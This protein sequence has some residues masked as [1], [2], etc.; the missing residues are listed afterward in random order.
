[1]KGLE[2]NVGET[3]GS[4]AAAAALAIVLVAGE[5][6]VYDELGM[7]THVNPS[8][9]S[10]THAIQVVRG[11]GRLDPSSLAVALGGAD[12]GACP[13]AA[14]CTTAGQL[15]QHLRRLLELQGTGWGGGARG[16]SVG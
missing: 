11:N 3:L 12:I 7:P 13:P 16:C 15:A 1:M 6:D 5:S 2:L 9:P 8:W 10:T 14:G 4:T